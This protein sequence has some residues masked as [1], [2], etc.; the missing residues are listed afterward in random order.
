V[1]VTYCGCWASE[2]GYASGSRHAACVRVR[3]LRNGKR[4]Y[5]RALPLIGTGRETVLDRVRAAAAERP[6]L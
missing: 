1:P 3:R 4:V 6:W 2:Q 5:N